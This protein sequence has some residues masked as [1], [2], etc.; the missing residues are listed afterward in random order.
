LFM[1]N[2]CTLAHA[3][4]SPT[5]RQRVAADGV[6]THNIDFESHPTSGPDYIFK[7]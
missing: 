7:M 2:R 3:S 1:I 5:G 4:T 6:Q